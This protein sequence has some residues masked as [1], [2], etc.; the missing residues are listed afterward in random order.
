MRGPE[1]MLAT[2]S[3]SPA[4]EVLSRKLAE[5][6]W[7]AEVKMDGIRAV[8]SRD[9][10]GTITIWNRRQV[11]IT[12]RYP[13]VVERLSRVDFVGVVDGEIVVLDPAGRP[14]FHLAHRRDAQ[15]TLSRIRR[16]A[17]Q[18]PATFMPFDMLEVDGR[19]IRSETYV[20]RRGYLA[21]VFDSERDMWSPHSQ[22][23]DVMWHVVGDLMLEG[24]ILKRGSSVYR[25]GRQPSWVKVK[26][27]KR[28]SVLV[29]GVVAGKGSRGPVGALEMCLLDP[30]AGR[31]VSVGRVGSGIRDADAGI[32]LAAVESGA[33]LVVEVEYLEVS[34]S[35]Q[36]RT[37]TFHGIRHDVAPETCTIDTLER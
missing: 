7:F 8:L 17:V 10:Y 13:D 35:G 11:D 18:I 4:S 32:I 34:P 27:T 23:L 5:G 6:G 33:A 31:L 2:A 19:D 30:Q 21:G 37:P 22:D 12:H 1:V 20:S 28:V 25:S 15:S 16:M 26:A 24:L 9:Q 29:S 36:L 14:T 3:R